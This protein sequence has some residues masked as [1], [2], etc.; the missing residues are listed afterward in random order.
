MVPIVYL[1]FDFQIFNIITIS[2]IYYLLHLGSLIQSGTNFP[3]WQ[4][5]YQENIPV[6]G[7]TSS[8]FKH[9]PGIF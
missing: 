4:G 2:F 5:T 9:N 8:S 6:S 1:P 3:C 7:S